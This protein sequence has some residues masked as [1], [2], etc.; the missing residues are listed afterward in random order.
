[1][2]NGQNVLFHHWKTESGLCNAGFKHERF[3]LNEISMF[4]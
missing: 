4:I 2:Y 3:V 1:M